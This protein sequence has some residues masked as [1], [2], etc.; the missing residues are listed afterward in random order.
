MTQNSPQ[1]QITPTPNSPQPQIYLSPKFTST[2][3]RDHFEKCRIQKSLAGET[4]EAFYPKPKVVEASNGAGIIP[5]K[6]M[7]EHDRSLSYA[8]QFP[9]M[10]SSQPDRSPGAHSKVSSGSVYT[11]TAC[12][13]FLQNFMK[14]STNSLKIF[15]KISKRLPEKRGFCFFIGLILMKI[16]QLKKKIFLISIEIFETA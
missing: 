12:W 8:T 2:Q 15:L 1:P 3:T 4:N 14:I 6:S 13:K 16:F 5:T 10:I 7:T 9:G 11:V